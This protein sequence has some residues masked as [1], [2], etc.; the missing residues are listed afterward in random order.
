[1]LDRLGI[2]AT[3][4]CALHC[5]L[6]PVLLPLLS[7]FGL[8]AWASH[9][10]EH[11]FLFATLALGSFALFSGFKNYHKKIYPFYL[12]FLGGFIYWHKHSVDESVQP[13][14]ILLGAGLLVA[15]H[16]VN[17]KLCNGCRSCHDDDGCATP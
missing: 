2:T 14:M 11:A 3:S 12:L 13:L 6:L 8:E 7:L 17:L 9:D 15:A 10:V 4:L 16:V 5:I 1:M